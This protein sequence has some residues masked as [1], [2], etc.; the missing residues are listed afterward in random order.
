MTT[1]KEARRF[2]QETALEIEELEE[3]FAQV[4]LLDLAVPKSI[5]SYMILHLAGL[6]E[7][8]G[9]WTDIAFG[10]RT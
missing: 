2:Q 6:K 7:E 9:M 5:S 4:E 8:H 10:L 1:P 3:F